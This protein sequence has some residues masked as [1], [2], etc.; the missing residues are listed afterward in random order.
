MTVSPT[1]SNCGFGRVGLFPQL[2]SPV[3]GAHLSLLMYAGCMS[4]CV[5]VS[6]ALVWVGC[7]VGVC[8]CV[9]VCVCVCVCVRVCVAGLRSD[10]VLC[11][12]VCVCVRSE[13]HTSELQSH[14]KRV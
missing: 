12:C 3:H 14:V 13:E 10:P 9:S 11:V 4:V 2:A 1:V 6:G 8:L 7:G 5:V